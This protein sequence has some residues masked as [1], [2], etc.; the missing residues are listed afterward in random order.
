VPRLTRPS[1][2]GDT[3]HMRSTAFRGPVR[4]RDRAA[5]LLA[6]L[7]LAAFAVSL[8]RNLVGAIQAGSEIDRLRQENAALQARADALAAE[9]ILL[10]DAA[11][12]ALLARGYGL[13]STTERPFTLAADA[14]DLGADAPGSAS[15]RVTT[16]VAARSPLESWG[17]LLFGD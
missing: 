17:D 13:G 14:P 1:V 6:A 12:V 7:L 16:T 2:R 5:L 15:R 11:F 10:D 9:R 4:L 8:L 3:L